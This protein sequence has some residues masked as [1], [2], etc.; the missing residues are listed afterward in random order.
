MPA[1]EEALAAYKASPGCTSSQSFRQE[2]SE[3]A[4]YMLS[5]W[6]RSAAE[7]AD[8][9][10]PTSRK[11]PRASLAAMT[12]TSCPHCGQRL[13]VGPCAESAQ[14]DGLAAFVEWS[15][16]VALEAYMFGRELLTVLT[17]GSMYTVS[18]VRVFAEQSECGSVCVSRA[19]HWVALLN[20]RLSVG[21]T[22][23]LRSHPQSLRG[24]LDTDISFL[25]MLM[26]LQL[27]G[28]LPISE[29]E[30]LRFS[31]EPG[32]L[33]LALNAVM[34][35]CLRSPDYLAWTRA[36]SAVY[37]RCPFSVPGAVLAADSSCFTHTYVVDDLGRCSDVT[38]ELFQFMGRSTAR[39]NRDIV[40]LVAADGMHFMRALQQQRYVD[41]IRVGTEIRGVGPFV[42]KNITVMLAHSPHASAKDFPWIPELLDPRCKESFVAAGTNGIA[43]ASMLVGQSVEVDSGC[44]CRAAEDVSS[45][46]SGFSQRAFADVDAAEFSLSAC[47]GSVVTHRVCAH[48]CWRKGWALQLNACKLMQ[49]VQV[50]TS[51]RVAKPRRV[52][53][54]CFDFQPFVEQ[55]CEAGVGCV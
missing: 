23:Q 4:S 3:A 50:A 37:K 44:D 2:L 14:S 15:W 16:D 20:K 28:V 24:L 49:A 8:P 55:F 11:R 6:R 36:F 13:L 21:S 1:V 19:S 22:P 33:G 51:G 27:H 34:F 53:A 26:L 39:R 5:L 43:F 47:D 42:M 18:S 52:R 38:K 7:S 30:V 9:V 17:A 41:V 40:G 32:P 35:G 31:F 10:R 48:S 29:S 46:F 54:P 45:V 12:L 25:S